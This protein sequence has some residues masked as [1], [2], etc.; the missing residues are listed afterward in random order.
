MKLLSTFLIIQ[1]SFL[2]ISPIISQQNFDRINVYNDDFRN[3][4]TITLRQRIRPVEKA[5]D[6]SEVIFTFEKIEKEGEKA[7]YLHCIISKND[8]G[9]ALEK[10]VN[11]KAN[12]QIFNI[13]PLNFNSN[14]KIYNSVSSIT[15]MPMDSTGTST[16]SET[17]SSNRFIEDRIKILLTPAIIESIQKSLEPTMIRFYSSSIPITVEWKGSNWSKLK[18]FLSH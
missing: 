10:E 7:V 6:V 1:A 16:S 8:Y 9:L 3:S 5:S 2:Y 12:N 18:E 4:K 15:V 14:Y 17:S 13:V 11:I